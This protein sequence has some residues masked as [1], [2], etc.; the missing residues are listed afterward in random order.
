[1]CSTLIAQEA[2]NATINRERSFLKAVLNKAKAMA[3]FS[4]EIDM[5][6]T[7]LAFAK[8]VHNRI[9][10]VAAISPKSARP[11][12]ATVTSNASKDGGEVLS[13]DV[14]SGKEAD[15]AWMQTD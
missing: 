5:Q 8:R 1:M 10:T 4:G 7:Q 2:S 11:S 15:T 14:L 13:S 3:I 6:Q 9:R 12:Q